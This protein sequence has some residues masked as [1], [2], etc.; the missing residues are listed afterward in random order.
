MFDYRGKWALITGAS[1]GIG[2]A[3]AYE[4]AKKKA[5]VLL[6]AR[7]K[8]K[9]QTLATELSNTYSIQTDIIPLDLATTEAPHQLFA[10]VQKRGYKIQILINNAG[11]GGTFGDLY[12][13]DIKKNEQVV[14]LNVFSLSTITRLF[15]PSMIKDKSGVIINVASTAAFQPLP[16][17]ANYGAS[18]AFV[19]SFTEA[20]WFECKPHG[21]HILAV[22]PGPVDTE[23]FTVMGN[24]LESIGQRDTCQT[25]AQGALRA[26]ERNSMYVI[27]GLWGNYWLAQA[28][29]LVPRKLSVMIAGRLLGKNKK[30]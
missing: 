20:L 13:A 30:K 9:L 17:Q 24:E 12:Q 25:V 3:F 29:R 4:L 10:E 28:N 2:E 6:V 19:L 5:N 27:P 11:I 14:L 21:L 26:I 7:R 22:C 15:L 16:Y 1:S 23:F 8:E 18:K